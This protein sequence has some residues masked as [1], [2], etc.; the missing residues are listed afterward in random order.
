MI[1]LTELKA[2]D[3]SVS[4]WQCVPVGWVCDPYVW[5]ITHKRSL[6]ASK[7]SRVVILVVFFLFFIS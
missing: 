3:R 5:D 4:G 6:V 1:S 7:R 2:V